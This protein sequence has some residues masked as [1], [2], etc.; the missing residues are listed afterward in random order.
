VATQAL[1][2][3]FQDIR[4]AALRLDGVAHRTP[5]VTA[6]SLNERAGGELFFKAEC[7]QRTGAFKFRGAYNCIAQLEDPAAGIV[8]SS[9]G[10]HAQAVALAARLTGR[11]AV[12]LMPSDAPRGKREA[13]E[14]YG[15]TVVEFDRYADDREV[16]TEA[17]AEREGLTV[18]HAYDDA[19]IVAGAGTASLELLQDV[20][21][22]DVVIAPV[23][24]GGMLAGLALAARALLPQARVIGVEP[25]ANAP[26]RRSLA[27]GRPTSGPVGET[28]ADGQQVAA[29]GAVNFAIVAQL[30]ASIVT[31][32]EQEIAAA[33]VLLL[34]RMKLVVEPSGAT[35]FAAVL[36]GK[37][38][39]AGL[40]A[41]V[42]LTGGNL[43]PARLAAL[44]P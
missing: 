40:R 19:R 27:A 24:G 16:L 26:M 18:V 25:E 12:I 3:T 7:L 4:D 23:G 29:P 20:A 39:V 28:I 17:F 44:R 34:E 8:T 42:M 32:S 2:A 15:A 10:N 37:V 22:L 6:R 9:S 30:G 21:G 11:R 14:A 41:G 36:A 31:V 33:T 38:D 43:D 35:A 13:T 5:V 1:P